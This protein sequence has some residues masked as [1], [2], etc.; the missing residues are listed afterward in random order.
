MNHTKSIKF[1]LPLVTA[2][3]FLVTW[4]HA[5]APKVKV[6]II[7]GQNNHKW[8]ETTPYLKAILEEAGVFTVN[9]STAPPSKP[10]A[11]QL[12]KN[13]TPQQQAAHEQALKAFESSQAARKASSDALWAK[14]RPR[15]S[16]YDVIVSNYNGEEWPEEV[17][18]AFVA[19]VKNGGGFVSYHAADNAF[20]GWADYNEM[21]ALGGWGG[22]NAKSGPYLRLREGAWTKVQE[23]GPCGGHGAQ[24][25]FLVETFA[26]GHPIMKGLPPKWMHTKD[27]LYHQLRGPAN[28]VN[29]LGAALSDA[30]REREPM[31]MAIS[32]GKGRIFH[33][34]L[35][36]YVEALQGLGFQVTFARGTEWAATGRVTQPAPKP[37]EL[38]EGPTAA[39]H[40]LKIKALTP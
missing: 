7:D 8:A 12:P 33:T 40:E 21:I 17:R 38:T 9:V 16:D 19:F 1:V 29:V 31:L 35:G 32:V 10:N 14:W 5:A 34:T 6:L 27:E 20:A 4:A 24:H 11:P 25:E 13:A 28:E 23:P 39:K 37:G 30:T 18:A 22:R 36:H 3:V 2:L 15:F 26:P